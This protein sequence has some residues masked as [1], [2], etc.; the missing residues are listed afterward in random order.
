MRSGEIYILGI[1]DGHNCGATLT[2]GGAIVASVSEER[3]HDCV[4]VILSYQNSDGGWATYENT[5]SYSAL[6]AGPSL[7]LS[8]GTNWLLLICYALCRLSGLP[9][10]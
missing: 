2:R 9:R 10:S 7:L 4:N 6:E 1:H 8:Y 3:L 5:R